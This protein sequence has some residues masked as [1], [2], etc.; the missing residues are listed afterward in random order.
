MQLEMMSCHDSWVNVNQP[1]F[2]STLRPI[3]PAARRRPVGR[4]R[5]RHPLRRKIRRHAAPGRIRGCTYA[6]GRRVAVR[7]GGDNKGSAVEDLMLPLGM[8]FPMVLAQVR[9]FSWFLV[10]LPDDPYIQFLRPSHF[11]CSCCVWIPITLGIEK[12][13]ACC[14]EI[15][16]VVIG[17]R[18]SYW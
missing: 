1:F 12:L 4:P 3:S 11:A 9:W 5:R 10:C 17:L 18:A 13:Q 16:L 7:E 8:S 15:N 14:F 6:R 2:L